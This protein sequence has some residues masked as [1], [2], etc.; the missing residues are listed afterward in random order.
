MSPAR[1]TDAVPW[2]KANN[3]GIR[4]VLS[5]NFID[6]TTSINHLNIIIE[7]EMSCTIS[8]KQIKCV[9]VC[10]VLKLYNVV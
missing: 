2:S 3:S 4:C 1:T 5:N 7:N 6:Q 9:V 10:K 8:C